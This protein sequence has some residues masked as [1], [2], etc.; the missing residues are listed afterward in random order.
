MS[1]AIR[2]T[3]TAAELRPFWE[4]LSGQCLRI[5]AYEHLDGARPHC[6]AY[7]EGATVSTD[8]MKNWIKSILQV[9][10]YPKSDWAFATTTKDKKPL[11]DGFVI[12][13]SKGMY[14]PVYV[15]GFTPEEVEKQKGK[16]LDYR[17]I[18]S[19]RK[20]DLKM[21]KVNAAE[22][23][24]ECMRRYRQQ[25]R[26]AESVNR[27]LEIIVDIVKQVVYIENKCICGRFK[28]R[29]FVDTV[30]AHVIDDYPWRNVQK[31]FI[32]YR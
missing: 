4:R 11:D 32:A 20:S 19:E 14:D 2:I 16:W 1:Y 5:I 13:M 30:A 23:M 6:H 3:N 26:L 24:E 10:T 21:P 8:T 27:S 31:D 17:K 12:Y 9:K 25:E 29:D 15:K 18:M 7:V 28:F 22:M